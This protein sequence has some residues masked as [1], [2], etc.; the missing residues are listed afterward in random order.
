M[1]KKL[2]FKRT[3]E[4]LAEY[5]K[6]SDWMDSND[7]WH[8]STKTVSV[9]FE[10]LDRLGRAVGRAYGEDT[11]DI[12]SPDTCEGCVRPSPWLRKMIG[13]ES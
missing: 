9:A 4:A 13:E 6:H 12:N 3:R 7:V 1:D 11:C 5:D 8:K 10:T 2:K